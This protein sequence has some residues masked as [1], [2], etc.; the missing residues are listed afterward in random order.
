MWSPSHCHSKEKPQSYNEV[1]KRS[2]KTSNRRAFSPCA[3]KFK[4]FKH[5]Y[6]NWHFHD[7]LFRKYDQAWGERWEKCRWAFKD[8][9]ASSLKI[10]LKS[11][12]CV[13]AIQ[14]SLH[15]SLQQKRCSNSADRLAPVSKITCLSAWFICA[16]MVLSTLIMC[17]QYIPFCVF[18]FCSTWLY[19]LERFIRTYSIGLA[20]GCALF[21]VDGSIAQRCSAGLVFQL[22]SE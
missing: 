14:L 6:L 5:I 7:L 17:S 18:L 19:Y 20:T 4:H 1:I 22:D 8:E 16:V 12:T 10:A 15:W 13:W 9:A 2:V 11:N 3:T 21:N